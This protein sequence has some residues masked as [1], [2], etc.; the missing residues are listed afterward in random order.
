MGVSFLGLFEVKKGYA[1]KQWNK[2]V[3]KFVTA[4]EVATSLTDGCF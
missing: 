2:A 4:S 1:D 3:C